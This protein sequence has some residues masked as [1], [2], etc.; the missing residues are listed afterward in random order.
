M[1]R[2]GFVFGPL[3]FLI[4]A[5]NV[6]AQTPTT[7][8]VTPAKVDY[9]NDVRP[10]LQENCVSCHGP[11]KQRGGMRLDR[12]SSAT[13]AFSRRIVPGSSENSFLYHRLKGEFG[14][15]MPPDGA[16]K[17]DQIATIKAW[18]D[19]GAEWPDAL[20]N[21]LDL[22]A[23]SA[24][25][26][27]MVDMLRTNNMAGFMKAATAE[28]AL[29]NARGPEGSTPFMYA[30]LY[31]NTAT[32]TQLLKMGADP[33][34]HNDANATAL[35]WAVTNLEKTQLL[36]AHGADV[37]AKSDDLHTPLMIAAR[38]P[39]NSATVK[40]LLEHGANANP[41]PK[42]EN[43]SSPLIEAVTAGDAATTE[44]LLAHGADGKA[45][46]ET[47]LSMSVVTSCDKC[48]EM[49]APL[50]TSKDVY[51]AALV[52]IA[53]YGDMKAVQLMLDHGADVKA[54]DPIGRTALMYAAVSDMLPLDEVK[55]LIDHGADVNA[56]SKHMN[57]GD[58]GESVLEMAKRN[59][60][61]PVVN[62]LLASG[63]KE[64]GPTPVVLTPRLKNDIR[65]A[66]QDS[67]PLLQT[68]D[69]N[70]ANKSGCVSCHN[71]SLTAMTVGLARK[72]GFHIDE[73][74]AAAQ[75]K[76][77]VEA[78]QKTRDRMHQGF[79][80]PVGDN[81]SEGIIAYILMGLHAEGYKADLNTDAAAM[82]IASR[83]QPTG[84]WAERTSDTR[85][86]LCLDYTGE[87]AM[88]M[89][90]LQLYAPKADAAH[91]Q[92]AI[93]MA[94]A[95][96]AQAKSYS[97]DDRG[98]RVAGLAWAG[99]DKE[100]T[101]KAI[102][103]LLAT[104]KADGSWS[105]QPAMQSTAYATGKSLVALS[106]GGLPVSN[107]AYQRGV[108]WLL[109]HQEKDGSWYVQTRALAF[110]PYFDAGFPHGHDQWMSTAGTN[111][112]VQALTLALPETKNT[113]AA[114]TPPAHRVAGN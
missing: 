23:P 25:T 92:K 15:P 63:A 50:V 5:G 62:L 98:W 102:H 3:Y 54:Y 93:Q 9:A 71:N 99:T 85:P 40:L 106:I 7:T 28:P 53:V 1:A 101:Q 16:L 32:L 24:K 88:S 18:I 51:T 78:L 49:I 56:K 81:F 112:A 33:N 42:P 75:L 65:L 79:L 12:K 19:Q 8:A 70:F 96:L 83:Q 114:R 43:E 4:M 48:L 59:G 57:A 91:Y 17:A 110:Q 113:T 20:A 68:A 38:K 44:L 67:I 34:K 21:E 30:V 13:K 72:Q 11:L 14:A 107:P 2:L 26:L 61:T 29:L 73:A 95:W 89:R 86:P 10:I 58:E 46:G 45:T 109:S 55:L 39:G 111:W 80:I 90:A 41:N 105:D 76:A 66:I 36:L 104:Q 37:N 87:T 82:D 84:E 47:G 60:N 35:M 64:G 22:P 31:A 94:A 74:T 103:E 69:A 77:N 108:K 52:D 97:N 27:A 6:L 100:A